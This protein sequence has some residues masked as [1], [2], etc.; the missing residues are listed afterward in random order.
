[1]PV[2]ES[3]GNKETVVVVDKKEN[4][5]LNIKETVTSKKESVTKTEIKPVTTHKK[6]LKFDQK[7]DLKEDETGVDIV[8]IVKNLCNVENFQPM[9]SYNYIFK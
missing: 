9:V 2:Q 6:D 3:T 4:I 7:P 1:M 8:N 5:N